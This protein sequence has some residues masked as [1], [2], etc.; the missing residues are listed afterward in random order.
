MNLTK[1]MKAEDVQRKL[2]ELKE[3]RSI[4]GKAHAKFN[5]Q[6]EALAVEL[7]YR[8]LAARLSVEA[9]SSASGLTPKRIRILMRQHGLDPKAGP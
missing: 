2:G 3:A 8:G 7:V 4:W 6:A 1:L 9:M 5:N